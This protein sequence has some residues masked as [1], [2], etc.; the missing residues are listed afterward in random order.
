MIGWSNEARIANI[1]QVVCNQR[2][3][4]LPGIEVPK[5]A[6]QVLRM[7]TQRIADDWQAKYHIRP[8]LAYTFTEPGQGWSYRVARWRCCPEL[9]SGPDRVRCS[10]FMGPCRRHAC[11]GQTNASDPPQMGAIG[12]AGNARPN[13]PFGP[14]R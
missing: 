9:T 1:G 5:L 13:S 7:A 2:L 10:G 11:A 4:I 8:V 6:S 12:L 14:Q 3:L